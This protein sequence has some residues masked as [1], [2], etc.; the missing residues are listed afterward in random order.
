MASARAV[1]SPCCPPHDP[2]PA[3]APRSG[4]RQPVSSVCSRPQP[5]EAGLVCLREPPTGTPPLSRRSPRGTRARGR[6][7]AETSAQ[8]RWPTGRGWPPR[9]TSIPVPRARVTG[10]SARYTP[11]G[12]PGAG[13][14]GTG[15]ASRARV[16]RVSIACG[17]ARV[18][19]ASGRPPS[20]CASGPD[21]ARRRAAVNHADVGHILD[22]PRRASPSEAAAVP[23]LCRRPAPLQPL[24]LGIEKILEACG[25]PSTISPFVRVPLRL[26]TI[27]RVPVCAASNR[28]RK[29]SLVDLVPGETG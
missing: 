2:T 10:R 20:P 9:P 14:R 22:P 11:R 13:N 27:L 15:K 16:F 19:K 21:P 29:T 25:R 18:C 4:G 28:T 24:L 6:A 3:R 1:A 26:R 23:T 5:R 12:V 17:P 8:A 7:A